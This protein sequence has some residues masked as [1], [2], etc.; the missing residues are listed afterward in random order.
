MW[1]IPTS[2]TVDDKTYNIR[3]KGD[4]RMVFDTMDA[5][6]DVELS[7][8]EKVISALMIFYEGMDDIESVLY[9]THT[10]NLYESMLKFMEAGDNSGLKT[11]HKLID[12]KKDETLIASGINEVIK[13]EVRTIPYLHWWTFISYFMAIRDG[14]LPYVVGIREKMVTGKKLEK[15]EREFMNKNPNYFTFVNSMQEQEQIIH[16]IWNVSK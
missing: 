4:Y 10:K 11:N 15:S 13:Q 5:L 1:T 12:W 7:N 9:N 3:K 16:E 8:D 2:I 6:N 14:S